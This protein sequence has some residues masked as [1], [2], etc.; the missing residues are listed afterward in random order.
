MR[1]LDLSLLFC[2]FQFSFLA[3]DTLQTSQKTEEVEET[4]KREMLFVTSPFPRNT[5]N[6]AYF[7]SLKDVDCCRSSAAPSLIENGSS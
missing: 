4:Q 7:L 1:A 5:A 3:D 6:S 2:T